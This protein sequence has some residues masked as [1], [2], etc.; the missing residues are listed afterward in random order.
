MGGKA[1]QTMTEDGNGAGRRR[2]RRYSLLSSVQLDVYDHELPLLRLW[3]NFS[4]H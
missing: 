3:D 2:D 1:S 4:V